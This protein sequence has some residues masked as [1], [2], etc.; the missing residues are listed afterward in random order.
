MYYHQGLVSVSVKG[1][2]KALNT[3]CSLRVQRCLKKVK[4]SAYLDNGC[5]RYDMEQ[6]LYSQMTL[7]DRVLLA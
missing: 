4:V 3:V 5:R 1:H 6:W 2:R 7:V